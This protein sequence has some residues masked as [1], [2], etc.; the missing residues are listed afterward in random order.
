MGEGE[1]KWKYI[2]L[3]REV[4]FGTMLSRDCC[5]EG[6]FNLRKGSL[7]MWVFCCP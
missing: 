7:S 6:Y 2:V 3:L 1:G 5:L 4:T